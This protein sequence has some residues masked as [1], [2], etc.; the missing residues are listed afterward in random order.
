MCEKYRQ[1]QILL[2]VDETIIESYAEWYKKIT[3][4]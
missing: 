2:V 3:F 4:H 1:Y